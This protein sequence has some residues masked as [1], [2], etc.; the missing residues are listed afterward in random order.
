MTDWRADFGVLQAKLEPLAPCHVTPA[1]PQWYFKVEVDNEC[2]G[3]LTLIAVALGYVNNVLM[4]SRNQSFPNALMIRHT[5][6]HLLSHHHIII[7]N[8]YCY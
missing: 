2:C 6:P 1:I 8:I 3:G 4:K 7:I 5:I